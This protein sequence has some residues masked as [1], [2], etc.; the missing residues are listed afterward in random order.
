MTSANFTIPIRVTLCVAG[1]ALIATLVRGQESWNS[2]RSGGAST[3]GAGSVVKQMPAPQ[4]SKSGSSNWSPAKQSFGA[5]SQPGG[6]WHEAI[7][8]ALTSSASRVNGPATR[9]TNASSGAASGYRLTPTVNRTAAQRSSRSLSR[10]AAGSATGR[11]SLLAQH[12]GAQNG[13]RTIVLRHSHARSTGFS[14]GDQS[15]NRK[16]N[17]SLSLAPAGDSGVLPT[18][19]NPLLLPEFPNQQGLDHPDQLA[20]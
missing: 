1:C 7:P 5:G 18:Q 12:S 20:H 2:G 11:N 15:G 13:G 14:S 17:S 8:P 6:V 10:S 9:P 4:M 19:S 3:W 16:S